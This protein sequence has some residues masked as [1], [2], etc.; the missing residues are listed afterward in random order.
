[1]HARHGQ[2]RA[3]GHEDPN[4]LLESGNST[5]DAIG[6]CHCWPAPGVSP[7]V[8]CH[9][10]VARSN[11][12]TSLTGTRRPAGPPRGPS[13]RLSLAWSV[14]C[15]ALSVAATA[16][17]ASLWDEAVPVVV[18]VDVIAPARPCPSLRA[19][20]SCSKCRRFSSGCQGS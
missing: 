5:R 2:V 18:A 7:L 20:T 6:I 15:C 14:C 19:T 13:L 12:A 16:C 11:P 4:L 9:I 8:P 1:M 10:L 17:C 3:P